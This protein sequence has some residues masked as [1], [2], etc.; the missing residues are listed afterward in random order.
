MNDVIKA[1]NPRSGKVDFEFPAVSADEVAQIAARARAA[2]LQWQSLSLAKRQQAVLALADA[3]DRHAPKIA[4]ALFQDTGRLLMSEREV[5]G[6]ASNMRRWANLAPELLGES[7]ATPTQKSQIIDSLTYANQYVPYQLV[8]FISPWNFPVTLSFIDAVPALMAGCSVIIKPSEVTSRFVAPFLAALAEVPELENVFQFVL[9]A[10]E[11]G[12][13]LVDNVDAICF[14][15]SVPTGRKIAVAAAQRFIP[16]F[17][18]LGGKDPVIVTASADIERATDA[19][20]RGSVL[21]SGQVCLSIE[22]V[23]VDSSIHDAFVE[24][25]Q[26]K[27][28]AAKLNWPDIE[29]GHVGPL[30]FAGQAD[31]IRRHIADAVDKGAQLVAGGKIENLGGGLY[32]QP[33][34]LTNVTHDMA[35][36]HEETFGPIMPVMSF[37]K[38][39]QAIEL[40]NDS[41]FGLSGSVI[42]GSVD[43]ARSIAEQINAGGISLND[44]GLTIMTY[45][46]EKNAFGLSGMGGS[47]MGP[48]SI[49][50]FLRKKAIISQMGQPT[51]ISAFLEAQADAIES[52]RDLPKIAV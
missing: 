36:M 25:L 52:H 9:G 15:G 13:A 46:P 39:E 34:I 27:A 1:V 30:I 38:I 17:L 49:W 28:C 51:P 22:R 5:S 18:E 35:V 23:Y 6:A 45:E 26:E 24:R 37:D 32:C 40:A 14:T 2:Q 12:A 19:V 29:D 7:M 50:R 20:L 31:I 10:G 4:G 44:C 43:E 41:E 8:G 42:A 16:A 47:R 11:T 3:V 48:A 33:T 21:N